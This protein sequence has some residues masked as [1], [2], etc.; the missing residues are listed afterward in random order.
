MVPNHQSVYVFEQM[1]QILEEIGTYYKHT[2]DQ[3]SFPGQWGYPKLAGWFISFYFMETPIYIYIY[4]NIYIYIYVYI[5]V[6]IYIYCDTLCLL[7][8]PPLSYRYKSW[9]IR[10]KC[11]RLRYPHLWKPSQLAPVCWKD[12]R[13]NLWHVKDLLQRR[14]A[15]IRPCRSGDPGGNIEKDVDKEWKTHETPMEKL[16]FPEKY[17][18]H[19]GF[20][21]SM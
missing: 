10:F 19:V 21:T 2:M 3:W 15:A 11:Y 17:D 8:E 5:Y 6:Y 12:L 9:K 18:L 4:T 1:K 16:W 13:T 20:S 7:V 14:P